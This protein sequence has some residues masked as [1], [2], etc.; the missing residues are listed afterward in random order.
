QLEMRALGA[1]RRR[2]QQIERLAEI[3]DRLEICRALTGALPPHVPA[4]DRLGARAAFSEM[5]C[6]QFGLAGRDLR[7]ALDQRLGDALMVLLASTL[8][9][10][11][12][13]RNVE[14]RRL[15]SLT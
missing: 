5:V 7:E 15:Q 14:Q 2:R 3:A 13:G 8:Q 12:G 11:L 6:D 9:Q 1:Q 10:R 4:V